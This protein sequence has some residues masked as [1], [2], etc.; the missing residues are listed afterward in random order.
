MAPKLLLRSCG[1]HGARASE[2]DWGFVSDWIQAFA[3]VRTGQI[4]GCGPSSWASELFSSAVH[5]FFIP[6]MADLHVV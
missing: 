1:L 6:S 4:C 3:L 5:Q 2:K